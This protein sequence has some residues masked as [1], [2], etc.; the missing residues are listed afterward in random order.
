MFSFCVLHRKMTERENGRYASRS[1]YTL[2][3]MVVTKKS[4]LPTQA[5]IPLGA[6][7]VWRCTWNGGYTHLWPIPQ[8]KTKR[9]SGK[10][11]WI[12]DVHGSTRAVGH[13]DRPLP[14]TCRTV[15]FLMDIGH[16]YDCHYSLS[17]VQLRFLEVECW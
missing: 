14:C 3:A 1:A 11:S 17:S 7:L 12:S 4:L 5:G 15:P 10:I 2:F 13:C 6:S 16:Q 9:C 8:T